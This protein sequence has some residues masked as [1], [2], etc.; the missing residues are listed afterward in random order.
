MNDEIITNYDLIK[1]INYLEIL[2]PNLSSLR[3]S[4]KRNS[5]KFIN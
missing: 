1:E 2:N 4:K 5:K 3:K